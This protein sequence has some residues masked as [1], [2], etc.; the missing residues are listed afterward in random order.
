MFVIVL[1]ST[2]FI[3]GHI[4]PNKLHERVWEMLKHILGLGMK[5]V[6]KS[7]PGRGG[8]RQKY[9]KR[10]QV[11]CTFSW[12]RFMYAVCTYGL[13]VVRRGCT[14]GAI[15]GTNPDSYHTNNV[16]GRYIYRFRR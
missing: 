6:P 15:R 3:L 10:T 12:T 14:C 7:V 9:T 16:C 2:S 5:G 11:W 8:I 1:S 4:L 13:Y